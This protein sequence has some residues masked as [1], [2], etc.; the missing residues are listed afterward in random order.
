MSTTVEP[1]TTKIRLRL[2]VKT[3]PPQVKKVKT[4]KKKA[5]L[6][7]PPTSNDENSRPSSP[8]IPTKGKNAKTAIASVRASGSGPAAGGPVFFSDVEDFNLEQRT[9]RVSAVLSDDEDEYQRFLGGNRDAK[10]KAVDSDLQ[11]E[12]KEEDEEY[13]YEEEEG[14]E[15][16]GEEYE[17]VNP[18]VKHEGSRIRYLPQRANVPRARPCDGCVK[19]NQ[20][21]YSQDS[22]K[23]RG[24]CFECG[25][26]KQK[27]I[28]SVSNYI[29]LA[30]KFY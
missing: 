16:N 15:G 11:S 7:D 17:D 6:P 20:T 14:E 29:I 2:P 23:T 1:T 5:P 26:L 28:Y 3:G 8:H 9:Q 22:E 25:R 19:R 10:Q 18:Y 4:Q 30:I 27:C 13:E 21:C 24:A 12:A